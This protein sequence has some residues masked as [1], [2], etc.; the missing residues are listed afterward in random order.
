LSVNTCKKRTVPVKANPAR[1]PITR[2]SQ[3]M[4][5]LYHD[6]LWYFNLSNLAG[7]CNNNDSSTWLIVS[8]IEKK[9][10][11]LY[12]M[13]AKFWRKTA[14]NSISIILTKKMRNR[15]MII[16]GWVVFINLNNCSI[17]SS[18]DWHIHRRYFILNLILLLLF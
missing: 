16:S 4:S 6:W 5:Y 14:V 17:D 9:H 10:A 15:Q 7:I 11:I 8:I 2:A 13:Q 18:C 3:V 1:L 12:Q